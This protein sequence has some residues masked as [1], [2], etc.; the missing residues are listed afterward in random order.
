MP[1]GP[2]RQFLTH[3][4]CSGLQQESSGLN[5]GTELWKEANMDRRLLIKGLGT[6]TLALRVSSEAF[7]QTGF[8]N[9]PIHIYI[10]FPAGS[11]G[12]ILGRYFSN[13]LA[14]ISPSPIIVENKPGATSNIALGLVAKAKPDG[15]SV[16]FV[17]NSNMAGS[18]Y[19]FKSLPFDTIEDFVPA[20]SFAQVV[21]VIVVAPE[22]KVNSVADLS[23]FLKTTDRA[24]YAYSNQ[25]GQL[26]AELF[27]SMAG[28]KA[29]PVSYRTSPDALPD[30]M[31][32]TVDFMVMDGT[33][34]AA[35]VRSGR[36]KCLAVTTKV[37]SASFP[38][39]PTMDEAGF[40]GYEFAPWWGA[41][42][43]KGTPQPIVDK[44]AGWLIEIGKM[45]ET[46]KFLESVGSVPH[47]E[48][49]PQVAAR[50]LSDIDQWAPIVK[51][52]NII[53][54]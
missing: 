21:F 19:L 34:A 4:I 39:V 3:M 47:H 30:V 42:F 26:A 51:A 9:R 12:D 15:Y 1:V 46:T 20:A 11:G 33:S 36:L 44:F 52:A 25:T 53:P 35:H 17:A 45:P 5:E 8:P 31:N 13:K 37:R 16:L 7:G 10:G 24:K 48:N 40:K 27:K 23:A 22:S 18:R 28:V 6:A 54:Q 32:G 14:A 49:G 50:I 2:T 38:G 29:E 41:F 43:P